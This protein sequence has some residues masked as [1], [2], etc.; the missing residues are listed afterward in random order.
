MRYTPFI[1]MSHMLRHKKIFSVLV[2]LMVA[3][4]LVA[5]VEM[6]GGDHQQEV[7]HCVNC[8]VSHHVAVPTSQANGPPVNLSATPLV[9]KVSLL[10]M[11]PLIQ[12]LDPPPKLIA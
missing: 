6:G 2:F 11:Q 1:E 5:A 10:A 4:F 8:C 12:R 3:A 9:A 7:H